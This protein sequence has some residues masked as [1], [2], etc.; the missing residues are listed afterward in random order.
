MVKTIQGKLFVLFVAVSL[1]S[2]SSA[3]IFRELI[4]SDFNKYIEGVREDEIYRIMAFLEGSYE[5][6][7]SWNV[8][9]IKDYLVLTYLMGFEVRL[10]DESDKEIM[11]TI[12]AIAS[13]TP[14]MRKRIEALTRFKLIDKDSELK[15]FTSYPLF[16]GGR[17]IGILYIKDLTSENGIKKE[18]LFLERSY[19][20]LIF[21][22]VV[23]GGISILISYYLSKRMVKPINELINTAKEIG[24]GKIGKRVQVYGD[25]EL[26]D[27]ART[28]NNMAFKL[29]M[30]ESLRRRL[31]TNIAHEL[32]TPLTS[33]QGELEGM[34]DG[35]IKID[36]ERLMSIYEETLRLIKIVE[37]MEAI[38]RAEASVLNIKKESIEAKTFLNIIRERFEKSFNDKGVTLVVEC[39]ESVRLYADPDKLSQV[40]I[41]LISNALNATEKGGRVVIKAGKVNGGTFIEISDTGRGIE[42]KDIPFIFERFYKTSEDGLGIGLA[43]TKE[44]IEAHGGRI[45][46]KSEIGRG[47]RFTV[48][49]EDN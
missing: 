31:T 5:K 10:F 36:R 29:E 2:L 32:R 34:I 28:F 20:F 38:A 49:L 7:G 8:D 16:L 13:A 41:N 35:L 17:N 23:L 1:I 46:V 3:F 21:S 45:E 14:L 15:R 47:S 19:L 18:Y 33:M 48:F 44:L 27:F 37:G 12:N 11:N 26:S 6:D 24:E 43:I 42:E 4:I 9:L 40:L 22:I 39:D 30:Q 25:D